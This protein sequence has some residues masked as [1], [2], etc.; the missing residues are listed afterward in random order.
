MQT[1]ALLLALVFAARVLAIARFGPASEAQRVRALATNVVAVL[2]LYQPLAAL[3][4]V[5]LTGIG[6]PGFALDSPADLWIAL[7]GVV[8]C[9]AGEAPAH[10]LDARILRAPRVARARRLVV[11][12]SAVAAI[13][14]VIV[15]ARAARE[16]RDRAVADDAR[17][18]AAIAYASTIA[19]TPTTVGGVPTDDATARFDR[20]LRARWPS[21]HVRGGAEEIVD[22]GWPRFHVTPTSCRVELP[23]E[24]LATIRGGA[25]PRP[26]R[27]RV[28]GMPLGAAARDVGELIDGARVTR[29]RDA[30]VR[31]T[32]D[33]T[34]VV[35]ARTVVLRGAA[36]VFVADPQGWHRLVHADEVALE[37]IALIAAG[38]RIVLFRPTADALLADD[39]DGRRV[40]PRG[41][42][43]P[44][45]GWVN[46][47]DVDRSVG[48]DGWIHAALAHPE[49][50]ASTIACGTLA[51]PTLPRARTCAPSRLDGVMECTV[52]LQPDLAAAL[53]D[54]A[55]ARF[56]DPI[57][58]VRVA[59]VALRGDTG[60]ILAQ[61]DLVAGRP[62]LAYPPADADAEAALVRLRDT[63]GEADEERPEWNL[64]IAVGSTLKPIV[65][66]AA[67]RAFPDAVAA[68]VL[69]AGGH[70]AG[71]KPRRG[72][73][74]DPI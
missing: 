4:V 49:S 47:Y 3:G 71:C 73:A 43:L 67:E 74:I 16:A 50:P 55:R 66:R 15:I 30:T 8:W 59:Y 28:V 27:I 72:V 51:P 13:A 57:A 36:E 44:E 18:D 48:L 58:P 26:P 56:A 37:R 53:R 14:T 2:V 39:A 68:L 25:H 20:E 23:P 41:D 17:L 65:A 7:A 33:V 32:D 11:I 46:P 63:P 24:V 1:A 54:V 38:P 61:G 9:V 35:R 60:E 45:L 5:P 19:C 62:S 70:A 6:W 10:V 12:A 40:Y 22:A 31:L 29:L 21:L 34:L 69:T 52:A 42:L 64:P